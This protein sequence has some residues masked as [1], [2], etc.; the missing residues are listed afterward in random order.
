MGKHVLA[1]GDLSLQIKESIDLTHLIV[2][3]F[4]IAAAAAI[5]FYWDSCTKVSQTSLDNTGNSTDGRHQ[6]CLTLLQKSYKNLQKRQ[7]RGASK[8]CTQ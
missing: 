1:G 5:M 6:T 8:D 3:I 2:P 7:K 4:G